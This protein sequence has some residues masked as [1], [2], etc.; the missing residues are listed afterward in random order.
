MHRSELRR[1]PIFLHSFDKFAVPTE[2][3]R[4]KDDPMR[5]NIKPEQA[6]EA[7]GRGQ[8]DGRAHCFCL[9]TLADSTVRRKSTV[10][11][12]G[13]TRWQRPRPRGAVIARSPQGAEAIQESCHAAPGLLPPALALGHAHIF[14]FPSPHSRSEWWGGVRGGGHSYSGVAS[15]SYTAAPPPPLAAPSPRRR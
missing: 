1:Q 14:L 5:Q 12:R 9:Q 15:A 8:N 6:R 13:A 10:Q 2:V 4:S 7:S 11:K 3:R